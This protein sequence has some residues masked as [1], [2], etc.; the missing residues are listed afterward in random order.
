MNHRKYIVELM[1][2]LGIYIALLFV[3]NAMRA[4]W[5]PA[6]DGVGIALALL[7][8]AGALVT[9]WAILRQIRRMDELQRRIQFEALALSFLG[10]ALF[11]FSWGFAETAGMPKFPTFGIWPL[12]AGFWI[13]GGIISQRRY[14]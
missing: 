13:V 8:M 7:P 14:S 4:H 10:T 1:S 5:H 3:S 2:G 9:A 11:T 12:M 6:R